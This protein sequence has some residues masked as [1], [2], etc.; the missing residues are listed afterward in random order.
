MTST[1]IDQSC[2]RTRDDQPVAQGGHSG[3]RQGDWDGEK[4]LR[5]LG[6]LMDGLDDDPSPDFLPSKMRVPNV[7]I[8]HKNVQ[9]QQQQ[10]SVYTQPDQSLRGTNSTF[11]NR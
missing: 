6:V 5:N 11:T 10:Q 4:K 3:R 9:Q 2:V 1:G 7:R 8:I